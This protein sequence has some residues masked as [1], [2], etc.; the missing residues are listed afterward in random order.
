[1][2]MLFSMYYSLLNYSRLD[3]YFFFNMLMVTQIWH[4]WVMQCNT[5]QMWFLFFFRLWLVPH[6]YAMWNS[7][8]Y[9]GGKL[10]QHVKRERERGAGRGK[11]EWN[12]GQLWATARWLKAG[13]K[14]S[15]WERMIE[16]GGW[17]RC[18]FWRKVRKISHLP[19]TKIHNT[20][21]ERKRDSLWREEAHFFT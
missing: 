1:M 9:A 13:N 21:P 7:Q 19:R 4:F 5:P 10:K 16:K 3:N 11:S 20:H 8:I 18:W 6:V 2:C 12:A 14:F 15:Q 17:K